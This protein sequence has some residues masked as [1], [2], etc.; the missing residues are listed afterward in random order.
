MTM[1]LKNKN[2]V[3]SAFSSEITATSRTVFCA[4]S[5]CSQNR[6]LESKNQFID[7]HVVVAGMA[8][9]IGAFEIIAGEQVA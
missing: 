4:G 3:P 8:V 7:E 1:M 6:P 2:R 5:L 9:S